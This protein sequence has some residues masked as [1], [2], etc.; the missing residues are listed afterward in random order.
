M[1]IYQLRQTTKDER[2]TQGDKRQKTK[3]ER[4]MSKRDSKGALVVRRLSFGHLIHIDCYR[5]HGP[6]DLIHL[7]LKELLKDKDAIILIEWAERIKKILPY[8]A[9][10][11]RFR[12]GRKYSERNI[13]IG[14]VMQR[15]RKLQIRGR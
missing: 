12:H 5:I 1:K 7:G 4:K 13:I 14:D 6:K 15:F 11:V 9:L 3:D 10:W 2:R 8:D